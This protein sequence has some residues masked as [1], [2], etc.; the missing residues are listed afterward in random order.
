MQHLRLVK[1]SCEH[2]RDYLSLSLKKSKTTAF[3]KF[4]SK[5]LRSV[6]MKA[7]WDA[8]EAVIAFRFDRLHFRGCFIYKCVVFIVIKVVIVI[9]VYTFTQNWFKCLNHLPLFIFFWQFCQQIYTKS[10]PGIY[11]LIFLSSLL[12]WLCIHLVL[13]RK[14]FLL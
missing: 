5:F 14:I 11:L 9:T 6:I 8:I 13:K 10:L 12:P 1:R 7:G 4:G 3:H 2:S